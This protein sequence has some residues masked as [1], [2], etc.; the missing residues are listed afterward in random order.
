MCGRIG[1]GIAELNPLARAKQQEGQDGQDDDRKDD[2]P[3]DC[4][5][6]FITIST[7]RSTAGRS[8]S[9]VSQQQSKAKADERRKFRF[10]QKR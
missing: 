10:R 2:Q 6:R 5:P 7:A 4:Q 9:R 8:S 3:D 1:V